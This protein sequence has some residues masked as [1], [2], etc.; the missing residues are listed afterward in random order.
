VPWCSTCE[1]Y[2][3]PPTVRPDGTCPT[4]GVAVDGTEATA[5]PRDRDEKRRVLPW[6]FKLLA[7]V[8][9]LY[10]GYRAYQGIEWLARQL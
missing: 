10:L 9:A 3:T 6:H 2:L 1:R 8:L 7:A 4:C 5:R